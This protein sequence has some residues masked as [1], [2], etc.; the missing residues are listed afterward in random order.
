MVDP[1]PRPEEVG[2]AIWSHDWHP[3]EG[4]KTVHDR[5]I[6]NAINEGLIIANHLIFDEIRQG[7]KLIQVNIRGRIECT[8]GLCI[9]VDKWLEFDAGRNVRGYSY[10]YH[11]W[12]TETN[13][14][15]IRYDSAYGLSDLHCH[16]FDLKTGTEHIYPVPMDR[17]PTLDAFI[18]IAIKQVEDAQEK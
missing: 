12:L 2:G 8:Y 10:S 7:K 11:A 14:E 1:L 16:L 17:L 5:Y 3:Y 18:R 15:V 9:F 6:T 4:Y 13:Q